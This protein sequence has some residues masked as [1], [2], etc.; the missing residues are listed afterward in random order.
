MSYATVIEIT[1]NCEYEFLKDAN[2]P[3]TVD[4]ICVDYFGTPGYQVEG[5]DLLEHLDPDRT[6]QFQADDL[7]NETWHFTA[8]EVEESFDV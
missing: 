2:F 6:E 5:S 1:D 7:D 8:G 4:A 3:F